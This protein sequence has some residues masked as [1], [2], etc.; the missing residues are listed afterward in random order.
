MKNHQRSVEYCRNC[1]WRLDGR[2][3]PLQLRS[4]APTAIEK[5][6]REKLK[7]VIGVHESRLRILEQDRQEQK[8]LNSEL[9][10]ELARVTKHGTQE[11]CP[12][13][14]LYDLLKNELSEQ[15]QKRFYQQ[16]A[17]KL[18]EIL[19]RSGGVIYLLIDSFLNR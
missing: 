2:V 9:K 3:C 16:Q 12:Q 1:L 6:E 13:R 7:K 5:K 18:I 11:E 19:F 10:Q 14:L 17:L 8:R 15:E 4:R